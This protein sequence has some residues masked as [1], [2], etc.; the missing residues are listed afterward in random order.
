MGPLGVLGGAEM[1][2]A[3]AGLGENH[4]FWRAGKAPPVSDNAQ[5]MDFG[6]PEAAPTWSNMATWSR[7]WSKIWRGG[8]LISILKDASLKAK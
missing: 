2:G 5:I 1:A 6:V 8:W 3:V 4:R 7:I